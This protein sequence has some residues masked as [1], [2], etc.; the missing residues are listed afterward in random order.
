MCDKTYYPLISAH[1]SDT[2]LCNKLNP[3][4]FDKCEYCSLKS[5]FIVV[6][7]NSLTVGMC[8][9]FRMLDECLE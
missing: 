7:G 1:N 5:K 9:F 3:L 6:H 2:S 4:T 8:K